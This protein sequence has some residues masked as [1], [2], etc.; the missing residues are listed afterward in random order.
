[1]FGLPSNQ[2]VLYIMTIEEPC[3]RHGHFTDSQIVF[4]DCLLWILTVIN[5][6]QNMCIKQ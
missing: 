5:T 1:M 3:K 6:H 4:I 2:N